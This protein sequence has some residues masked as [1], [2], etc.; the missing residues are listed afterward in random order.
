MSLCNN[1]HFSV[2]ISDE[3]YLLNLFVI[4]NYMD[5]CLIDNL[6]EYTVL[7]HQLCEIYSL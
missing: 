3:L 4:I 7:F 6:D 5:Y 2:N 1:L